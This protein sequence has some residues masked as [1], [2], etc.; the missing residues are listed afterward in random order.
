M[1]TIDRARAY[2]SRCPP[3]ISGAGGHSTT[4]TVAVAP[5]H[6]FS[7]PRSEAAQLM[8]EYNQTCV[9]PWTA[10]ELEHKLDEAIKNLRRI[11]E[12]EAAD[13]DAMSSDDRHEMRRAESECRFFADLAQRFFSVL[14]KIAV[15]VFIIIFIQKRPQG[16]FAMKGRSAEA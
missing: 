4:Y 1:T 5:V 11:H 6:G 16:I 12:W 15:L 7:L 2:L 8:A 14:A 3:A 9:P 10:R 13:A